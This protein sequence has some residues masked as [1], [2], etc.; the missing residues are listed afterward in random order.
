MLCRQTL[1]PA[2]CKQAS[3]G[4]SLL[5]NARSLASSHR[6]MTWSA[7]RICR[8][9]Q[10]RTPPSSTLDSSSI[11][12]TTTALELTRLRKG[13]QRPRQQRLLVNNAHVSTFIQQLYH[14]VAADVTGTSRHQNS[15]SL[16]LDFLLLSHQAFGAKVPARLL[17]WMLCNCQPATL[18][19]M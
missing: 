8:I 2:K 5:K 13:D 1:R 18:G 11:R 10:P 4:C 16:Q 17:C 6:S 12:S 19:T 15:F 9:V 7:G 3:N 14:C